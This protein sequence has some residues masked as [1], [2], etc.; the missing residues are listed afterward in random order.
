MQ[1]AMYLQTRCILLP[2]RR[3]HHSSMPLTSA[4]QYSVW[5]NH[6]FPKRRSCLGTW[7]LHARLMTAPSVLPAVQ[8]A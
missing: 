5:L 4:L 1:L 3:A 2:G 6:S 8:H 7:W